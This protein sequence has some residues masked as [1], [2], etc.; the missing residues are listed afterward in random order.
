M[1]ASRKNRQAVLRRPQPMLCWRFWQF[2]PIHQTPIYDNPFK[3][4]KLSSTELMLEMF[5]TKEPNSVQELLE[6]TQEHRCKDRWL[7]ALLYRARHGNMDHK[8]YC[9][10][11]GLPTKHTGSWIPDINNVLCG[12]KNCRELP[13]TWER[14]LLAGTDETWEQRCAQ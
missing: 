4:H 12:Q 9:F 14:A 2:K 7:S 6:L 1:G 13:G 10:M 8:L 5:W 11:H 3:R